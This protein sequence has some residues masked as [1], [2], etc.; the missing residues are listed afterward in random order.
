MTTMRDSEAAEVT[1]VIT[2]M[3]E[4][5]TTTEEATIT[6]TETG[7]MGAVIMDMTEVTIREEVD[8]TISTTGTGNTEAARL[9]REV[10]ISPQTSEGD[11]CTSPVQ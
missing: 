10:D 4:V 6:S 5:T 7:L 2:T 11:R 8:T 3:T 1:E 9:S